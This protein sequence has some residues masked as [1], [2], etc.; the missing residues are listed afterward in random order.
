MNRLN[1]MLNKTLDREAFETAVL[2]TEQFS[3]RG[4][5]PDAL[6]AIGEYSQV[7]V[8]VFLL[9]YPI[10]RDAQA[11][12]RAYPD[13]SV[14]VFRDGLHFPRVRAFQHVKAVPLHSIQATS[15]R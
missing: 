9:K 10:R 3:H 15:E 5:N 7:F 13:I 12:V 11:T 1:R 4:A 6:V 8:C 2:I 14:R